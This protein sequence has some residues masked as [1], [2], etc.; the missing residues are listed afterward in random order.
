[1][2]HTVSGITPTQLPRRVWEISAEWLLSTGIMRKI[3]S[4][5]K[6]TVEHKIFILSVA[7][8]K[9]PHSIYIKFS[10]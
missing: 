5:S 7:H 2:S 1:M 6:P 10:K 4:L 3:F 9:E 8:S